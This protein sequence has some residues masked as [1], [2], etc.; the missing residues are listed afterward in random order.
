MLSAGPLSRGLLYYRLVKELVRYDA[1]AR[2][3]G[4]RGI[5]AVFPPQP[6]EGR[7]GSPELVAT[8]CDALTSIVPFYWKRVLCLQRSVVTA[9]V[10]RAYG[11]S[12]E[13]VIGYRLAPFQGHAWVEVGGRIVND[14]PV[15]QARMTALERF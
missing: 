8:V 6:S 11:T 5:H 2:V 4:F 14:S 7:S 13:V 1:T 10:L 3:L 12:A 9:R 15:F